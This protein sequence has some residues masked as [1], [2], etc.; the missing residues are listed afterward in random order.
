MKIVNTITSIIQNKDGYILI[1][2][3]SSGL[4]IYKNKNLLSHYQHKPED[5]NSISGNQISVL[6]EDKENKIWIGTSGFGLNKLDLINNS[7][8]HYF[9]NNENNSI[10]NNRIHSIVE[11]ENDIWVGTIN[12]L[13]IFKK[14]T[15]HWINYKTIADDLTSISQ[16]DIRSM[17]ID[18]SKNIWVGTYGG[19]LNKISP[20]NIMFKHIKS[21]EN[22]FKHINNNLVWSIFEDSREDLWVGTE[23]G[24]SRFIKKTKRYIYYN[25]LSTLS[26]SND[27]L[28]PMSIIEDNNSNIWIG[29]DNGLFKYI[30][31]ENKFIKYIYDKANSNSISNNRIST[32]FYDSSNQLWIGTRKGLNRYNKKGNFIRY[33]QNN[34]NKNIYTINEDHKRN[35]WFGISG[36]LIKLQINGEASSINLQ[37]T[38]YRNINK[39]YIRFIFFPDKKT[40]WVGTGAGILEFNL[41]N[42]KLIKQYT[43]KDG[44]LSNDLRG[45]ARDNDNN[46]WIS[47]ING[48]SQYSKDSNSFNNYTN[49]DGIQ[50]IEFNKSVYFQN[51]KGKIFFGGINGITTFYPKKAIHNT[52]KPQIYITKFKLFNKEVQISKDSVLKKSILT[53][54]KLVLKHNEN[55]FTFEFSALDYTAPHK[56][57]YKYKLK[58]IDRDWVSTNSENRTANYTN[59]PPGNYTFKVIGSNNDDLWNT[60][61]REIKVIIQPAYWQTLWFKFILLGLIL[62]IC[63]LIFRFLL[64][65]YKFQLKGETALENYFQKK[66]ITRREKEIIEQIIKKKSNKDIE[67]VLFISIHTVRNHKHNIFKKLNIKNSSELIYKINS[68]KSR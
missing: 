27:P 3:F 61:G 25:N 23:A 8:N 14:K 54:D 37:N 41:N 34:L 50:S 33:S 56:N 51:K 18:N 20:K 48:I 59:I 32:L 12:G 62:L 44:L 4:Y 13:S 26:F 40:L 2:T 67:N 68:I 57:M 24:I 49:K 19:G 6:L 42:Y 29:S 1:G 60:R 22:P 15:N 47:T 53:S 64:E 35:L 5:K 28:F 31:T 55:F 9:F 36:K 16:N 46:I 43:K 39:N 7:F 58:G 38:K 21:G 65:K 63:F 10:Q 66:N 17:L 52:H 30:R 45:I 11:Y